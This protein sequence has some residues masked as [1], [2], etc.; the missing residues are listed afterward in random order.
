VA[1]DADLK[2]RHAAVAAVDA[3]INLHCKPGQTLGEM[4]DFICRQYASAGYDGEWQ[5]HHQGGPTGYA[6][7]DCIATPNDPTQLVEHQAFA[8]NPSITGTKS[9]DTIITG[10]NGPIVVTEAGSD[11]PMILCE[12]NGKM[13]KRPDILVVK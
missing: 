13:M 12:Y 5:L 3:G 4:F 11:W 6:T 1:I 9:E 8:W 2:K 7:R 10:E